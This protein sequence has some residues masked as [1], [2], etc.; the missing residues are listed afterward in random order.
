ME[1]NLTKD[2]NE[3]LLKVEGELSIYE[4]S[5]LKELLMSAFEDA[6][7]IVVDL[8]DADTC[9][10]ASLQ[11]LVSAGKSA[12]DKNLKFNLINPQEQFIQSIKTIGCDWESLNVN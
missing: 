6:E 7:K 10:T 12:K 4:V 9:D 2:N 5:K 11:M 8:A 1:L 3:A